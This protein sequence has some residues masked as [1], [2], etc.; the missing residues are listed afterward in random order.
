MQYHVRISLH[1]NL[2][3]FLDRIK[4]S[5]CCGPPFVIYLLRAGRPAIR[6]SV[7]TTTKKEHISESEVVGNPHT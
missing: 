2:S 5:N 6:I 1:D 3:S 4:R 7:N